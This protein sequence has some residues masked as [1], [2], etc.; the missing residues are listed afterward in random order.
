[1]AVVAAL[2]VQ[3]RR[4]VLVVDAGQVLLSRVDDRHLAGR[5]LGLALPG[6]AGGDEAEGGQAPLDG[7]GSAGH[8][9]APSILSS[10]RVVYESGPAFFLRRVRR[11]TSSPSPMTSTG[12]RKI[13]A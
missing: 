3:R 6:E 2:E 7:G 11:V 9:A 4:L 1:V 13:D 10:L 12:A 8:D 5:A